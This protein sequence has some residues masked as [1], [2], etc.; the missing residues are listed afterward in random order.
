M[1]TYVLGDIHGAYRAL[2]QV[3]ERSPFRPGLDRLIHLGDVADGW[4]ETPECVQLLLS[5]PNSIWLQGNHDWWVAEWMVTE[6]PHASANMSWLRQGGQSTYAAYQGGP[7]EQIRQHFHAF[8][9]QQLPYFEDEAGNLY[10]HGGYDPAIA[11]TRQD[12][13]DLIWNRELWQYGQE[14]YHYTECFI[15]HTPTAPASLV[16][17][18]RANV[19][20]L[21]QGAGYSGRLS[22]MNVRTKEFVQSDAVPK[23]YPGVKGR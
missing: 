17:C 9:S 23:L 11:I 5:I 22:L 4:P 15:G 12:P 16:P 18:Q 13:Y 19:W 1:E 3:L 10:V 21:D 2:Q 8:F 6:A 14:A 7:Q 20:N